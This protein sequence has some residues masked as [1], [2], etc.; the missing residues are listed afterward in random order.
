MGAHVLGVSD[1][2]AF[3]LIEVVVAAGVM[4]GV[5]LMGARIVAAL[6]RAAD[7]QAEWRRLAGESGDLLRRF[8]RSPCRLATVAPPTDLQLG[9][10]TFRWWVD[11][12]SGRLVVRA[13]PGDA[14]LVI[15]RG[16]VR[17]TLPCR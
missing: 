11:A 6:V 5:V 8:A 7:R 17:S 14:P 9:D 16:A 4:V 1:R 12:D 3:T 13:W 10:L 15:R 2:R